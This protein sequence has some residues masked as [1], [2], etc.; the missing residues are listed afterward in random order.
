MVRIR[1]RDVAVVR[2]RVTSHN[3]K[4]R[5]RQYPEDSKE[6]EQLYIRK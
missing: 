4:S 3:R 6:Y 5:M 2:V 1:A